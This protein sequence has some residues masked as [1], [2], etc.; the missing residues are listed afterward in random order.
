MF[1]AGLA[2]GIA[3]GVLVAALGF[4]VWV[5]YSFMTWPQR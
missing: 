4:G 5:L 3:I 2:T 1:L